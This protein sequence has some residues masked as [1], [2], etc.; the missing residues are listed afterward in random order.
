M[1]FNIDVI[2]GFSVC[3]GFEFVEDDDVAWIG[4][5][6]LGVLRFSL[7]GYKQA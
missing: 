7:V 3:L 1:E 5:L 2:Q 4:V 6:D